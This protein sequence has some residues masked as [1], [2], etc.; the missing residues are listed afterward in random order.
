MPPP[1]LSDGY[2]VVREWTVERI[3]A[4]LSWFAPSEVGPVLMRP[5][6]VGPWLPDNLTG[7]RR[8]FGACVPPYWHPER[9]GEIVVPC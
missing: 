3:D 5:L 7:A 2:G 6:P 9:Y 8:D 1:R 4:D